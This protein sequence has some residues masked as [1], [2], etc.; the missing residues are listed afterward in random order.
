[1]RPRVAPGLLLSTGESG[2]RLNAAERNRIP[3]R[4]PMDLADG[5]DPAADGPAGLAPLRHPHAEE[6]GRTVPFHS[7]ALSL[8]ALLVGAAHRPADPALGDVV[9]PDRFARAAAIH[10][11]VGLHLV[12]RRALALRDGSRVLV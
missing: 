3:W 12:D 6:T 8:A 10:A 9:A 11:L 7:A 2:R 5:P 4:R 1:L